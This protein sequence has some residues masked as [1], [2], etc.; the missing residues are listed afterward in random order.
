MKNYVR[1][2]VDHASIG[3]CVE[4]NINVPLVLLFTMRWK[5]IFK[6]STLGSMIFER[7]MLSKW[8]VCTLSENIFHDWTMLLPLISDEKSNKSSWHSL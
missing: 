1:V 5:A 8:A 3:S 6:I 2:S 7:E 4:I